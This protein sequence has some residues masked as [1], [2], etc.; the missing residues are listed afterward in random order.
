MQKIPRQSTEDAIALL[1][2]GD[3]AAASKTSAQLREQYPQTADA[4]FAQLMCLMIQGNDNAL[5]AAV[6]QCATLQGTAYIAHMLQA[7]RHYLAGDYEAVLTE[8]VAAHKSD[9]ELPFALIIAA[10][11]P[12]FLPLPFIIAWVSLTWSCSA[13][14]APR[15][16]TSTPATTML[17]FILFP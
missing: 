12:A 3:L 14:T 7:F 16:S 10:R 17:R 8:A 4:W 6:D 5:K 2:R 1:L 13:M 9:S 11:A 15:P